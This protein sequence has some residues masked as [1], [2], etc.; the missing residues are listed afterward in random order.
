MKRV[1]WLCFIIYCSLNGGGIQVKYECLHHPFT[2]C[3]LELQ[4]VN[5]HSL[6][7]MRVLENSIKE[8]WYVK[9]YG[10]CSLYQPQIFI[11]AGRRKGR[12][13]SFLSQTCD[14]LELKCN[15]WMSDIQRAIYGVWKIWNI[16]CPLAGTQL[17]GTAF[18]SPLLS[19]SR[20]FWDRLCLSELKPLCPGPI[21]NVLFKQEPPSPP[22]PFS[23]AW[24]ANRVHPAALLE[25]FLFWAATTY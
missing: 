12:L 2:C 15:I 20:Q 21:N 3:L 6:F 22:G 17:S 11:E 24:A 10:L 4:V 5:K 9:A 13:S 1:M 16:Q 18:F 7:Q 23:P 19:Q 25:H 8:D 14:C